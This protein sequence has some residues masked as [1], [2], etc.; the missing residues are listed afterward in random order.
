MVNEERRIRFNE[1]LE[2][3]KEDRRNEKRKEDII[4]EF[5]LKKG[6]GI[7]SPASLTSTEEN[8]LLMEYMSRSNIFEITERNKERGKILRL[9]RFFRSKR[10][11]QVEVYSKC[12]EESLYTEGKVSAIGRDFVMLTNLKDR[13]WIPYAAIESAN[14]PYGMPNYSNTHQH[15]IYDN[16]LQYNLIYNFGETVSK[17]DVLKQQFYE[18]SLETNLAT[19]NN[20]WVEVFLV[21]GETVIGKLEKS[22]DKEVVLKKFRH[23]QTVSINKVKYIKTLR[24]FRLFMRM[25]KLNI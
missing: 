15:F 13:I 21:D 22:S 11:Q 1:Y 9:M 17:R 23:E 8:R 10:N 2:K 24:F 3:L 14:I 20:T 5:N 6:E 18:E 12:G 16:D 25:V 7:T 4:N 19:W